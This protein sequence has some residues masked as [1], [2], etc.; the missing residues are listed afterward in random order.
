MDQSAK[1]ALTERPEPRNWPGLM[2]V[3]PGANVL[4]TADV[5]RIAWLLR[6]SGTQ[7]APT[8]LL[9]TFLDHIGPSGTL[10]VPTFNYDLKV[11]ETYDRKRT[12]TISGA[13][14]QAALEHPAF[15]RTAHPLHSF[16]VAGELRSDLVALDDPSSF[17]DRSPF[18]LFRSHD[19]I[20]LGLDMHLNYALSYFHHVEE[21][22]AVRYRHWRNVPI[23]VTD[24][25]GTRADKLYR[26]YAK[27]PGYANELSLLAPLLR[28]AGA[29]IEGVVQGVKFLR[30][31]LRKAHEVIANDIR[32]N[33]ARSI[34]RFTWRNWLRDTLHTVIP[35]K[36][37]SRSAQ[38]LSEKDAGLL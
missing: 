31:D 19:F 10:V 38:L 1:G 7:Q 3:T 23:G 22:E 18:A 32:S 25:D 6:R 5:T 29:M 28:Q 12:P 20:L 26:L 21:L 2:S 11:G 27:R 34:V 13:L 24:Q 15:L 35:H 30:V 9:Q 37:P 17:S 36:G 16:A 14:G 8:A 33:N 4:L